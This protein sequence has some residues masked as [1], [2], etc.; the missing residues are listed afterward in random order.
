MLRRRRP[1]EGRRQV[2]LTPRPVPTRIAGYSPAAPV[3]AGRVPTTPQMPPPEVPT[4]SFPPEIPVF[5]PPFFDPPPV[6][7]VPPVIVPPEEPPCDP[8]KDPDCDE[9]E[10]PEEPPTDVPEPGVLILLM[11]GASA[12]WLLGRRRRTFIRIRK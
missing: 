6:H 7:I 1:A 4:P 11:T 2:F 12:Y 8:D 3:E 10:E 9:P 5:F